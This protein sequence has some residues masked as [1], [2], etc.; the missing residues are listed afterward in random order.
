MLPCQNSS[1]RELIPTRE[2]DLQSVFFPALVFSSFVHLRV[3]RGESFATILSHAW[4]RKS[5]QALERIAESRAHRHQPVLPSFQDVR[6]L[7]LLPPG[8]VLQERV[9]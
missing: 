3:L 8:R 4:K 7:G 1:P 9:H 6:K 2:N 5:S